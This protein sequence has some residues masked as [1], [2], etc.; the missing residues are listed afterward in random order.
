MLSEQLIHV[1]IVNLNIIR[2]WYEDICI[3]YLIVFEGYY[4][5]ESPTFADS[6]MQ[7]GCK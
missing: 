4:G 3:I 6:F 2:E 7:S 5:Y 1:I